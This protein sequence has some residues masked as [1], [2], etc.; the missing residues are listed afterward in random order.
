MGIAFGLW[1]WAYGTFGDI[2]WYPKKV[3]RR[4]GAF[5]FFLGIVVAFVPDPF[6]GY[7]EGFE[8]ALT[9]ALCIKVYLDRKKRNLAKTEFD[10]QRLNHSESE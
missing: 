8:L 5:F 4:V 2:N 3:V 10:I 1:L 7:A 6:E 9:I